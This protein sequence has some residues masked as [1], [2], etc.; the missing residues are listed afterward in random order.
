MMGV[1][2]GL[3][4]TSMLKGMLFIEKIIP[5]GIK[6]VFLL[7]F[8]PAFMCLVFIGKDITAMCSKIFDMKA[9]GTLE[10]IKVMGINTASYV[11]LP[12]IIVTTIVYPFLTILSCFFSL[13]GGFIL[14]VL[15]KN[16]NSTDFAEAY[17]S[18]YNFRYIVLCI[19]KSIVFGFVCGSISCFIGYTYDANEK[20]DLI[21]V[22]QKCFSFCCILV[23]FFDVILNFIN[24]CLTN[25]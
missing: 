22:S 12:K 16:M 10:S 20:N 3:H 25:Q 13:I 24:Y 4:L 8:S 23:L 11:C 21:V 17:V 15:I 1:V 9:K 19:V 7:E 2:C 18:V 14:C 6:N 5:A